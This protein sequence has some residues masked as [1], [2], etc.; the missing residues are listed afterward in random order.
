MVKLK[1]S[2]KRCKTLKIGGFQYAPN[3]LKG[4]RGRGFFGFR[5]TLSLVFF[6]TCPSTTTCGVRQSPTRTGTRKE[7]DV[8]TK[9]VQFQQGL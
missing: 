8:R 1:D 6:C 5:I 9:P 2:F 3:N 7:G 4:A